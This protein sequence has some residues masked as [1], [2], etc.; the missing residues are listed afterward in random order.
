MIGRATPAQLPN[1]A[2]NSPCDSLHSLRATPRT[3]PVQLVRAQPPIPPMGLS[4]A[5][6]IG[7]A[8][9]SPTGKRISYP[10]IIRRKPNVIVENP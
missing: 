4:P 8:S 7:R 2:R 5:L 10:P 1:L 3:T 6:G 9:P